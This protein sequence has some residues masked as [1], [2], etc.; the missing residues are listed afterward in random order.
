MPAPPACLRRALLEVGLHAAPAAGHLAEGSY[1][2]LAEKRHAH[3]L[4]TTT[5]KRAGAAYGTL[6][7]FLALACLD[8]GLLELWVLVFSPFSSFLFSCSR[9]CTIFLFLNPI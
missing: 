9:C 6:A 1:A 7:C 3:F 4:A 5:S 8:S 2:H